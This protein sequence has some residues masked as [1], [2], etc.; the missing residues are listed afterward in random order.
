[1][2]KVLLVRHESEHENEPQLIDSTLYTDDKKQHTKLCSL[3]EHRKQ[4][5]TSDKLD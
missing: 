5:K 1:M 3:K 2:R 4:I